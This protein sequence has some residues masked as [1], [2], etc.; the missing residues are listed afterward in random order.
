MKIVLRM[1]VPEF[2]TFALNLGRAPR[3]FTRKARVGKGV[4]HVNS[5][6]ALLV[7]CHA[8]GI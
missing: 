8:K 3:A 5:R 6:L 1:G 7:G 4:K 2:G